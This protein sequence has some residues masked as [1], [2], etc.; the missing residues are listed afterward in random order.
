MTIFY[1]VVASLDSTSQDSVEK[2]A[3]QSATF[4]N[5]LEVYNY[6]FFLLHALLYILLLKN[7]TLVGIS[8]RVPYLMV[9]TTRNKHKVI[10][11][12]DYWLLSTNA[13]LHSSKA[14]FQ[15]ESKPLLCLGC[16]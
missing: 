5:G 15:Y 9:A 7:D 6:P 14:M 2:K 4:P 12:Y 8:N 10:S 16:L 3:L 1:D 13:Q 11:T